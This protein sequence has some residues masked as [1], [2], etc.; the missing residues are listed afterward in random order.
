MNATMVKQK[1]ARWQIFSFYVGL[2]IV[3]SVFLFEIGKLIY[4]L[5]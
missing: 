5:L 3:S 1:F 4:E 2:P